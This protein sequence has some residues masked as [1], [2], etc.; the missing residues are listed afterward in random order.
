MR[1]RTETRT[2]QVAH[3]V[4]GETELIDEQYTVHIPRPPRDWDSIGLTAV[5]TSTAVIVLASIGWS[6]TGIG[7]LLTRIAPAPAAY[8]AAGVFDLLWINCMLLEWLARYDPNRARTPQYAGHAALA[9]AMAAVCAHGVLTD[10]VTVGIVAAAVS[11]L[12]KAGWTLTL[13]EYARPLD[14]RTQAWLTRRQAR[15][16]AKLALTAQLRRLAAIEARTAVRTGPDPDPDRADPD[17]DRADL[18]RSD[19]DPAPASELTTPM[20]VKDAVRT[21]VDSGVTDPDEVLRYVRKRSDANASE[22]TVDRY[23]RLYRRSA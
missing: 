4:D 8:S 23:L 22:A 7:D 18:H 15:V 1:T 10:S 19:P 16:G 13:R 11:A 6:T 12:A 14:A 2:R 17:P 20:N 3:T 9:I 5:T 21:A